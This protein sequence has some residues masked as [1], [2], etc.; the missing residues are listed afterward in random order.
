MP[1]TASNGNDVDQTLRHVALAMRFGTPSH[2]RGRPWV[3]HQLRQKTGC[4]AI[5]VADQDPQPRLACPKIGQG[6]ECVGG[7]GDQIAS[8]KPLICKRW[9]TSRTCCKAGV[10]APERGYALRL[11]HHDGR[12][13][14]S[15]VQER[16]CHV[17][18]SAGDHHALE[19]PNH[20]HGVEDGCFEFSDGGIRIGGSKQGDGTGYMRSCSRGASPIEGVGVGARAGDQ[21]NVGSDGT[22][23]SQIHMDSTPACKVSEAI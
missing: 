17:Q 10:A 13:V 23:R 15:E 7:T 11:G 19:R 20:V 5:G 3:H 6:Q 16:A 21:H 1:A 22:W 4:G 14:R 9:S 18:P 12:L 8:S 2:Y